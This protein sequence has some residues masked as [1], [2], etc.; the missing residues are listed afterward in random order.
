MTD[1]L[2]T[3]SDWLQ[4]QRHSHLSHAVTY[5]RGAQSVAVNA[6]VG[7]T[8]FQVTGEDG[9]V[10]AWES[11]DFLIR[12]ADLALGGAAITPARGDRISETISG[13]TAV[14]E[15]MGPPGQPPYRYSDPFRQTFRVHTKLVSQT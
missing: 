9:I 4:G 2:Q 12:V 6:T 3:G 13:V 15:V 8:D 5:A 14:Y 10:E 1:L 11:R 7:E